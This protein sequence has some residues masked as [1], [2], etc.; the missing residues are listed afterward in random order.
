MYGHDFEL[1][2]AALSPDFVLPIGKAKVEREGEGCGTWV[3]LSVE[4]RGFGN[5][6][7]CHPL[8]CED[9]MFILFMT[10]ILLGEVQVNIHGKT[11]RCL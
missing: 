3:W 2:D 8:L 10:V 1:S 7:L 5:E 11:I 4:G 6:E 9:G